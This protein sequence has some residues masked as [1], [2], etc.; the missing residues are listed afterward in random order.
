[1]PEGY[2]FRERVL[3]DLTQ[4]RSEVRT[5]DAKLD[6]LKDHDIS[7]MKVEIGML[8]VKAGVWGLLGGSLGMVLVL[9]GKL[10][11]F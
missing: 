1:M 6:H 4:I 5:I 10:I 2:E 7:N 8:K 3:D 11:K 9:L